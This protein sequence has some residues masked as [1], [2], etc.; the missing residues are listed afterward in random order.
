MVSI[1]LFY[2]DIQLDPPQKEN[3]INAM[4]IRAIPSIDE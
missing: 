2:L 4:N 3:Y 1:A